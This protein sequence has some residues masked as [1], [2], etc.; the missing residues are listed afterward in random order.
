MLSSR[1]SQETIKLPM[2]FESI[3]EIYR[4]PIVATAPAGEIRR[5]RGD[6]IKRHAP[7][8]TFPANN[9]SRSSASMTEIQQEQ[10]QSRHTCRYRQPFSLRYHTLARLQ[11]Q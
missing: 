11:Q 5:I 1:Q 4:R 9:F 10:Q 7:K 8:A 3:D 2:T 6:V